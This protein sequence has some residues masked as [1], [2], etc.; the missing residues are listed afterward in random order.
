M[1]LV[2]QKIATVLRIL[3]VKGN[4]EE[5]A[6]GAVTDS[7]GNIQEWRGKKTGRATLPA[8]SAAREKAKAKA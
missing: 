3:R 4:A 5:P 8:A 7:I 1:N 6:F 2:L